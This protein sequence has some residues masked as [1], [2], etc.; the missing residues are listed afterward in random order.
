ML[1]WAP[2]GPRLRDIMIKQNPRTYWLAAFAAA[3]D[4]FAVNVGSDEIGHGHWDHR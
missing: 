2:Y 4:K 1:M 3:A